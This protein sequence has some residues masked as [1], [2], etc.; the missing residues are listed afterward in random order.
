MR[1]ASGEA[2]ALFEPAAGVR[3]YS[4]TLAST[5]SVGTT[6][7]RD[8]ARVYAA[9]SPKAGPVGEVW[10]DAEGLSRTTSSVT[11]LAAGVSAASTTPRASIC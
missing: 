7:G 11:T 10:P 6:L 1:A 3:E 9:R 2:E 8:C 5:A 4:V